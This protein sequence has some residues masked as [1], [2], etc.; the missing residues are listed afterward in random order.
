MHNSF[1]INISIHRNII[2]RKIF[3]QYINILNSKILN[4]NN[5]S[6]CYSGWTR[7][8]SNLGSGRDLTFSQGDHKGMSVEMMTEDDDED[9]GGDVAR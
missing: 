8:R 6:A 9:Y 5:V 4:E 7:R 3:N 1:G 2:I